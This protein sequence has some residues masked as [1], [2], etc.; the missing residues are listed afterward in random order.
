MAGN[1]EKTQRVALLRGEAVEFP[2]FELR[3]VPNRARDGSCSL[4]TPRQ[5]ARPASKARL[6]ELLR[7]GGAP[8]LKDLLAQ[9]KAGLA[10]WGQYCR[11]GNASRAFR[12]SRDYGELKVRPWL[13][14]RK[15]RHKRSG[16]GRRWSNE[17]LYNVL[18]LCWDWNLRPLQGAGAYP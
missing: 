7:H 15:R 6:R 18:G 8:P 12:E 11:V 2:G 3:R 1:T 9:L 14:R 4:L 13:T 5:R 16:G 17:S 10:G